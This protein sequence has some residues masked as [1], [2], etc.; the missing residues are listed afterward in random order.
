MEWIEERGI[1][2]IR[3]EGTNL[4][5]AYIGKVVSPAKF[6]SGLTSGF[7]LADV[8]FGLDMG[9]TPYYGFAWPDWRGDLAD[10]YLRPDTS[11]LIEWSPGRASVIGDFWGESKPISVCPRNALRRI[12]EGVKDLGF[13]SKVAIEVEAT[14]FQESIYEARLKGYRDL[15]PLGGTSGSAYNLTKSKDW[16]EYLFAVSDRLDELGI[17]WEAWN[18]ES[19]VGQVEINIAPGDPIT[20]ADNWA[21]TR[22]VMREVAN[23]QGRVVTFMAKWSDE[24]GQA[25]HINISLEKDGVNAFY[26]PE[27]P[28]QDMLHFLGGLMATIEGT[29]SFAMPWITSFRRMGEFQ[30]PPTTT[31]WGINNKSTAI[32]AM[33]KHPKYSRLEYRVPGSDA[34]IYLVLA[35]VLG[36]G[37]AGIAG[38]MTPPPPYTTMAW[39]DP[40]KIGRLP[41]TITKAIEALKADSILSNVMGSEMIDYWAGTRTWEWWNYHN[42]G[43]N[44]ESFV[45]QWESDRYFELS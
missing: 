39:G 36:T 28:S 11:T 8:A 19:A 6:Q 22:Q 30:G 13:T 17:V 16:E 25:S 3:V 33:V 42:A 9:A 23:D 32:R 21:R 18:D 26:D 2:T 27:G 12:Y 44:P 38:Q 31:T 15:T 35:A 24:W 7:A 41:N 5:G 14:V 1:R 34:N 29:T 43:G 10:I 45:T 37:L 20:V 40:G 4:D